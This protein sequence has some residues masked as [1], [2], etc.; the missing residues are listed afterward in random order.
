MLTDPMMLKDMEEAVERIL[1]SSDIGEKVT[2]YGDYDADGITSTSILYHF[3]TCF[4]ILM[5]T[6]TSRQVV[7]R[8]WHECGSHRLHKFKRTS[9]IITVDCGIRNHEEIVCQKQGMM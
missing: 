6:F 7:G 9:L 4:L 2:I 1:H 8:L 3:L 5:L